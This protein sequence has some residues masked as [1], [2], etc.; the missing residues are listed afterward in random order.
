[1]R[2]DRLKWLF[3]GA[4]FFFTTL[5]TSYPKADQ[6]QDAKN[7]LN[8]IQKTITETKKKKEEVINQKNDIAAQIADLD[9]KT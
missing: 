8:Q 5:F 7:K 6:L 3:F 9:K 2:G 4:M 1:M